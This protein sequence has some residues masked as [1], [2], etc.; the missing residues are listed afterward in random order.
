GSGGARRVLG[1][2]VAT[3]N[4]RRNSGRRRNHPNG[5]LSQLLSHAI[6]F[7]ADDKGVP[8]RLVRSLV[9]GYALVQKAGKNCGKRNN[10]ETC[11]PF[12]EVVHVLTFSRQGHRHRSFGAIH[13]GITGGS[14]ATHVLVIND[15]VRRNT[16]P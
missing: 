9:G 8:G 1:R 10:R 13:K 15:M 7:L 14:L 5:V 4:L 16:S 3:C 6:G 2:S 11:V 12:E